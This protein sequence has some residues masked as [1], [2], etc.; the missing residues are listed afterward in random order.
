MRVITMRPAV[1]SFCLIW[2]T[3]GYGEAQQFQPGDKVVVLDYASLTG[4]DN[5]V[6]DAVGPGQVVTVEAVKNKSLLVSNGR[7]GWLEAV[8]VV[9]LNRQAIDRLTTMIN[10]NPKVA[11]LCNGRATVWYALGQLD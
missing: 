7:P 3:T 11:F 6:V 4:D 2:L 10:A 9:P 1:I 8:N 5:A